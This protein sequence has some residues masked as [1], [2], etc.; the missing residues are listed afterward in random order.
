MARKNGE[1]RG[2]VEKPKGSGTWWV[3]LYV[4]GAEKWHRCDSKSQA[5]ALY[6]RIRAE[7][8][9]ERYF[10]EKY[11]AQKAEKPL[12]LKEYVTTWL[13]NQPAKGKKASTVKTYRYRLDKHVLPVFGSLPLPAITRAKSKAWAAGLLNSGLDYDTALNA[14]LTL[15]GVLSEAVEDGLLTVNPVLHAGKI[16]KRPKTLAEEELVIFTPD[17]E[18]AFLKAVK[19]HRPAFY[20][21][22]LTFFRTGLRAGEV[23]G[24]HRE[25]LDFHGRAVHVR[26][27]WSRGYL[28]TPKNGKSR[29]VDMSHGLAAA[30]K[31]WLELQDLEAAHAGR[32]R[33][34]IVFPGNTGGTRRQPSYMAENYLRYKL[35]FPLL[36][37]AKV[38]RLDLHAAR[39]TFASRLIANGENL[40]YIAEQMGHGSIKVTV[41]IYGHLIPGGNKSAVDRLDQPGVQPGAILATNAKSLVS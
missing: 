7:I 18:Q 16:I 11:K 28:D 2:I 27:Q 30:L 38:R 34:E 8:R 19:E 21:M 20:P 32:E 33:S 10:P 12:L 31:E 4:N 23:R 15:S 39:H 24:L 13:A 40:K 29:K 36:E 26:R 1:D 25:D 6:G 17:E 9:E 41:D 3:R 37:K 22:A 5:R 14:L 35:W